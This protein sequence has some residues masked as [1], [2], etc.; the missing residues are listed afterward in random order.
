MKKLVLL[1]FILTLL[2]SCQKDDDV[3]VPQCNLA[4]NITSETPTSSTVTLNWEHDTAGANFTLEYGITG[5]SQGMG[6]LIEVNSTSTLLTGL[7]ANTM[8]DFYLRSN[9]STEN[10]SSWTATQSFTTATKLVVPE[11]S[12][13]LSELN[14]YIGDLNELNISPR[15]FEYKLST[16]LFTDYSHKQRIIA[17][18]ENTSMEYDGDGLPIFPD[19][20]VIAKTFFYNL[21]DRDLSLG[22]TIIETRILL[23]I[24]GEWE[25]GDYKWNEAQTEA[26]LDQAG[27]QLPIEWIDA[28]GTSNSITYKIPSNAD[29]AT[30]HNTYDRTK[31]IGPKLRTL[32]FE[33]DGVNQLEQFIAND[34][35]TG[36]SSSAS[37]RN[38]P[39][40]EDSAVSLESRARAYMDINCAHCHIPGGHCEEESTLNL[41][42]ETSLT[43]SNIVER[44]FSISYRISFVS[45]GLSMPFIGTTILHTEGVELIQSYLDTL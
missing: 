35:L 15:A 12:S 7:M 24:D 30:C 21:D 31:P 32:N 33:I 3:L 45:E 9:C 17:L 1:L 25:T 27:S 22:R 38:L 8:Y 41:A 43:E 16:P 36:V 39:N 4:T 19:N 6:A 44:N 18:P 29:C 23:K 26:V 37:V 42:Y 10:F 11:L 13:N 5:F 34:Q 40:W 20:T 14:I 2:Y 28:N